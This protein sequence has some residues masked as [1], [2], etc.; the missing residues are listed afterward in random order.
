MS[1]RVTRQKAKRTIYVSPETVQQIEQICSKRERD[2]TFNDFVREALLRY[3]DESA[4]V[5]GSRRH[6]QKTL[7]QR[8]GESDLRYKEQHDTVLFYLGVVIHLLAITLTP[9]LAQLTKTQVAPA[10]LI[11]RAIA[12]T[13]R[14]EGRIAGQVQAA[15]SYELPEEAK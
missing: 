12:E 1:D 14:S 6:F 8:F 4:S 2:Y 7:H 10:D 15:R 9:L 5:I 3:V 11:A 13:R